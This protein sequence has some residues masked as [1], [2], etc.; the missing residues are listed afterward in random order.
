M[1]SLAASPSSI[2]THLDLLAWLHWLWAGFNA[3]IGIAMA[4]FAVA[5]MLAGRSAGLPDASFAASVTAGAF[6]VIALAALA[7]SAAHAWC[8]RALGRRDPFGRLVTLGLAV[9]DA[10]LAPLGTLLAA[11]T[12]W[13]LLQESGR[14]RFGV[15]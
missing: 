6:L 13:L 15:R 4:A 12:I 14:R 7:W 2:D 1:T 10:L 11:Y 9:C 3:A 8:A 5:A